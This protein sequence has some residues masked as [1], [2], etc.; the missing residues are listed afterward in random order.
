MCKSDKQYIIELRSE[1]AISNRPADDTRKFT[2]VFFKNLNLKTL[3]ND[4]PQGGNGLWNVE[5]IDFIMYNAK[6]LDN[7]SS[8]DIMIDGLSSPYLIS[9]RNNPEL[10][11]GTCKATLLADIDNS[12]GSQILPVAHF[13][14][15]GDSCPRTCRV[16]YNNWNVKLLT[17]E[18][19]QLLESTTDSGDA[20]SNIISNFV[21]RLKFTPFIQSNNF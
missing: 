15:Y 10:I 6:G 5:I 8:I 11:L 1:D 3:L 9:S 18:G 16:N 13:L 21:L 7:G 17:S 20:D 12:D 4:H 14:K 2:D 19:H